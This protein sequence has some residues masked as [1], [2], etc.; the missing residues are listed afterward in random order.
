MTVVA[1]AAAA[2]AA[3]VNLLSMLER[4]KTLVNNSLCLHKLSPYN[5]CT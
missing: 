5:L 2:S 4:P 3:A 1:T